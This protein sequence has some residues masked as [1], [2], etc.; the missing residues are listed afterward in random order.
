MI[1][2]ALELP[3]RFTPS[4]QTLVRAYALSCS[5]VHAYVCGGTCVREYIHRS[6]LT[7]IPSPQLDTS[8][9]LSLTN[10][11]GNQEMPDTVKRP[12][13]AKALA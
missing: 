4:L 10:P 1:H 9:I 2:P 13:E 6:M 12:R 7:D 11:Q 8:P 5:C 3:Q